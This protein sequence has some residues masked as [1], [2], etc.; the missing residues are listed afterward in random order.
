MACCSSRIRTEQPPSNR[1]LLVRLIRICLTRRE[2][3]K[4]AWEPSKKEPPVDRIRI[5]GLQEF[6]TQPLLQKDAK[7]N[8][9]ECV[10]PGACPCDKA[11]K[12]K[13]AKSIINHIYPLSHSTNGNSD[14]AIVGI[15]RDWSEEELGKTSTSSE[16]QIFFWDNFIPFT[17]FYPCNQIDL[18]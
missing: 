5:Q 8:R 4:W 10:F 2:P 13:K 9:S 3:P 17:Q 11:Q 1:F 12:G 6:P 7:L 18:R 16:F 14:A 15:R